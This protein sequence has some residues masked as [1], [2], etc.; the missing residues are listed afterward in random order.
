[1]LQ[2]LWILF[3]FLGYY[4][5]LFLTFDGRKTALYPAIFTSTVMVMGYIG[6]I[7]GCM[8]LIFSSVF[9]FGFLLIPTCFWYFTRQKAIT[10]RSLFK[11]SVPFFVFSIGVLW[12]YVALDGYFLYNPDDFSHWGRIARVISSYMRFPIESDLLTHASYLPGSALFIGYLT[13]II[14]NSD[15]NWL[16]A[17]AVLLLSF[18]I[19]VLSASKNIWIQMILSALIFPFMSYNTPLRALFVD[20]LLAASAFAGIVACVENPK[21][22]TPLGHFALAMILCAV[23]LIKTSGLFLAVLIAL[24]TVYLYWKNRSKLTFSL[25]FL[26]LPII[27]YAIWTR[28]V[29]LYFFEEQRHQMSLDN[30]QTVLSGKTPEDIATIFNIILPIMLN[31]L[32]NQALCVLPAYLVLLLIYMQQKV[33]RSKCNMLVFPVLLFLIYEIGILLMYI[34]SMPMPEIIA[35]NGQDY[36]RYNGTISAVLLAFLLYQAG[37]LEFAAFDEKNKI[38]QICAITAG[39]I[40]AALT[41]YLQLM[42]NAPLRPI[43]YQI[44]K[45]QTA[46]QFSL[47]HEDLVKVPDNSECIVYFNDEG[48]EEYYARSISQYYLRSENISRCY[49]EAEA[50]DMRAN[51]PWAY[52]I[53]LSASAVNPPTETANKTRFTRTDSTAYTN[54]LDSVGYKENTRYSASFEKDIIIAHMD[55]TGYFSAKAGDVI[56]LR[57]VAWYPATYDKGYVG[58]YFFSRSEEYKWSSVFST[59]EDVANWNP[60]YDT[61][62]NIVQITVPSSIGSTCM[63]RLICQDIS[64]AS[65]ITINE[66]IQ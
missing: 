4:L 53:D 62:G 59:A 19:S 20:N 39:V 54:I 60:V 18:W 38:K 24:Y 32:R 21:E 43:S 9:Y 25:L 58:V 1:M 6:G 22:E 65:I 15:S 8:R 50:M 45:Y 10:I 44:S 37:S 42:N 49:D 11:S 48:I 46:Y 7:I 34:F 61:Q 57:N 14:G 12:L 28:Y 36:D 55:I 23:C 33:L 40:L 52:Y 31:P 26:I 27:V 51:T 5:L 63:L 17:Q 64:D 2:I 35:Q 3:S 16:F 29:D 41:C 56:R 13:N 66:E 47:L 30:Y